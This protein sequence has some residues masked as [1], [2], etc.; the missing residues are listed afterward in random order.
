MALPINRLH[1]A[2]IIFSDVAPTTVMPTT[3][4]K[5]V[6][7]LIYDIVGFSITFSILV[8]SSESTTSPATTT[9]LSTT[10]SAEDDHDMISTTLSTTILNTTTTN[11][12]SQNIVS[13]MVPT[14]IN[15]PKSISGIR[16]KKMLC[17][18]CLFQS[19]CLWEPWW[20]SLLL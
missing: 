17:L 6:Y 2:E 12:Q 13:T 16:C 3:L 9:M 1:L 8:V 15:T 20:E 18:L 5:I 14:R 19:L 4:S 11:G 10:K 7:Y